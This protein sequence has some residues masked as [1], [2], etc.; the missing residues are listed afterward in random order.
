M[1][2]MKRM[3]RGEFWYVLFLIPGILLFT[4]AVL[5]PF[6]IGTRYSFTSWDGVSRKL[7]YI[8]W[9]NY[10]HAF[11]DSDVW[12][13]LGNTFKYAFILMVLVNVLS[14][15]LALL[16][17]SYLKLKNVFRTIFFLPSILSIVLSGFIWKY[18]FS[19][20][21]PKLLSVFGLD[22]TSP[23]GN[24]DHALFGLILVALWQ[25]VGAPMIIYIAGLQGIPSELVESAKMDGAGA[26]RAF[27]HVTLPLLA[28]SITINLLLVLTGSLKVFDLVWV[29]T[30]GGPGFATEVI[31]TFIYKTAFNSF[32]AGYGMALSMIFFVILVIVT[33]VQLSIFRRREVEM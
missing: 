22:V 28:P 13:A 17:D 11:H 6:V 16:L 27:W 31:T 7:T 24:P 2:N 15:L 30:Q 14:L 26:G 33:I 20:G 19:T 32:K 5:L 29:T 3:I 4:L 18:N 8:G 12:A 25:G 23:L 9:E 1:G 10:V 21:F